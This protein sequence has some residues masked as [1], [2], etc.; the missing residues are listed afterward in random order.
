MKIWNKDKLKRNSGMLRMPH[1]QYKY[2]IH[3][4][5]SCA[6]VFNFDIEFWYVLDIS[7][8]SLCI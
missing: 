6:Q 8:Y 1:H 7:T 3:N 5:S 4:T 2:V